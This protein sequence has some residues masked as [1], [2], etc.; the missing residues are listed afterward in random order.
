MRRKRE[1]STKIGPEAKTL[2]LCV[3]SQVPEGER[4]KKY[5]QGEEKGD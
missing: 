3:N 2:F 4:G 1:L 5:Y